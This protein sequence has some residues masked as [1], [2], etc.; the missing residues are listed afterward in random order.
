MVRKSSSL[1]L[2]DISSYGN[3]IIWE[4]NFILWWEWTSIYLLTG[5]KGEKSSICRETGNLAELFRGQGKKQLGTNGPMGWPLKNI[6]MSTEQD[7]CIWGGMV[8]HTMVFLPV[9][10]RQQKTGSS[11]W[12][13]L[14]WLTD[15]DQ[16]QHTDLFGNKKVS[17]FCYP[18]VNKGLCGQRLACDGTF[19]ACTSGLLKGRKAPTSSHYLHSTSICDWLWWAKSWWHC[20]HSSCILILLKKSSPYRHC[21]SLEY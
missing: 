13:S 3:A 15:A 17:P 4:P 9:L 19:P 18:L 8:T 14:I 7:E 5:R 16:L 11:K 1:Y 12:S 2:D 21:S 10:L 6:W 20:S